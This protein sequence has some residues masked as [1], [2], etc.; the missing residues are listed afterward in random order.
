MADVD[1]KTIAIGLLNEGGTTVSLAANGDTALYTVPTGFRC[2]LSEAHLVAGAN[3][4][5]TT[6]SIGGEASTY[7]DFLPTNTLATSVQYDSFRLVPAT[8]TTAPLKKSYAAG[9]VIYAHVAAHAGGASN[10]AYLF[11]YLYPV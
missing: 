9:T 3:T 2:V 1:L 7:A 11:G 10:K 6:V 8:S 4:G 5:A